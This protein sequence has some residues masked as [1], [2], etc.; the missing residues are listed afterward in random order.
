MVTG[1][2]KVIPWL[3]HLHRCESGVLHQ[4]VWEVPLGQKQGGMVLLCICLCS[5]VSWKEELKE[6]W[7]TKVGE[8]KQ[9]GSEGQV[10]GS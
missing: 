5:E 3:V 6:I 9:L 7:G 1:L 2:L 4:L 8:C 10:L